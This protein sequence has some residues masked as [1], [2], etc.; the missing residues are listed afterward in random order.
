[1]SLETWL[2]FV[3]AAVALSLTPGPNGLLSVNHGVRYGIARAAFTALGCVTGMSLLIA[4]SMAGLGAVMIA[5]EELFTA[6]KW[7]GAAYLVWLGIML[8]REPP[9]A[10]R[11]EPDGPRR[12]LLPIRR[13]TAFTHGFLVAVSNPKALLFFATFLPQFMTPGAPVWLQFVI[14]AGTYAVIEFSYE[15]LLAGTAGRLAPWLERH[16]RAFNRITGATFMAIAAMVATSQ[17]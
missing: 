17:R 8:W 15:L 10:L 12:E 13:H 1:M 3:V 6:L 7:A 9:A 4:V 5:S 11:P 2:L 16:G 14:F